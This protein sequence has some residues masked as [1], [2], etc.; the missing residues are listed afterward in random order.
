[1]GRIH[2]AVYGDAGAIDAKGYANTGDGRKVAE[3]NML[4]VRIHST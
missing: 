3:K 2:P 4:S 1:M